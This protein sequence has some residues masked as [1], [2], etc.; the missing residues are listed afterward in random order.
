MDN[1]KSRVRLRVPYDWIE[2]LKK[3][4]HSITVETGKYTSM[5]SLIRSAIQD[6]IFLN[7]DDFKKKL[8]DWN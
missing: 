1:S 8:T 7:W 5:S 2:E 6:K 3:R 4:A